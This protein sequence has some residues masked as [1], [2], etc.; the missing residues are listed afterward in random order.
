MRERPFW[1]TSKGKVIEVRPIRQVTLPGWVGDESS[2]QSATEKHPLPS[3]VNHSANFAEELAPP[4][5]VK[6]KPELAS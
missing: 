6:N 1:F 5:V 2:G 3:P 4:A